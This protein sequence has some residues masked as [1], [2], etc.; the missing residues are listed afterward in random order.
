L[1]AL[2]AAWGLALVASA[3][4]GSGGQVIEGR[5]LDVSSA[6][7]WR[8]C[9]DLDSNFRCSP[10]EPAT[11]TKVA[12][13]RLQGVQSQ[14]VAEGIDSGQDDRPVNVYVGGASSDYL[15]SPL[16]TLVYIDAAR[17]GRS[18]V[19]SE[20]EIRDRV[21]LPASEPGLT[22]DYLETDAA[23]S[24]LLGQLMTSYQRRRFA[25]AQSPVNRLL[26]EDVV[27]GFLSSAVDLSDDIAVKNAVL[28]GSEGGNASAS[29]G[30]LPALT[31]LPIIQGMKLGAGYDVLGDRVRSAA[32]CIQ[33]NG[34]DGGI[35]KE[36]VIS[37]NDIHYEYRLIRSRKDLVEFLNLNS[38]I[39][40]NGGDFSM[41]VFFDFL[42]NYEANQNKLYA[43]VKVD[44]RVADIH[45][46][47]PVMPDNVQEMFMT[48]Y[49]LFRK[50]C[51][52]QFLNVITVGGVYYGIIEIE[53]HS[54]QAKLQ[55]EAKLDIKISDMVNIE[56]GFEQVLKNAF[57]NER[58]SV[59]IHS[60]GAPAGYEPVTNYSGFIED[61]TRFYCNLRGVPASMCENIC[62]RKLQQAGESASSLSQALAAVD[63]TLDEVSDPNDID[64]W[65]VITGPIEHAVYAKFEDYGQVVDALRSLTVYEENYNKGL[66]GEHY[67]A[68][69]QLYEETQRMLA[70]PTLWED[71]EEQED[72]VVAK[73]AELRLYLDRIKSL[74][75]QCAHPTERHCVAL[76]NKAAL[77]E[78]IHQGEPLSEEELRDEAVTATEIRGQLPARAEVLPR[79]C[80]DIKNNPHLHNAEDVYL[81]YLDGDRNQPYWVYCYGMQLQ[82]PPQEYLILR[83]RSVVQSDAFGDLMELPNYNYS[84]FKGLPLP[85]PSSDD[86]SQPAELDSSDTLGGAGTTNAGSI[87]ESEYSE[88]PRG[89]IVS[90]YQMIKI[91]VNRDNVAIDPNQHVSYDEHRAEPDDLPSTA[92]A[93][94]PAAGSGAPSD[95]SMVS[96]GDALVEFRSGRDSTFELVGRYRHAPLGWTKVCDRNLEAGTVLDGVGGILQTANINIQGTPFQLPSDFEMGTNMRFKTLYTRVRFPEARDTARLQRGALLTLRGPEDIDEF[97]DI[98]HQLGLAGSWLN[99]AFVGEPDGTVAL[100]WPGADD[101]HY[102]PFGETGMPAAE[103]LDGQAAYL[104]V[105]AGDGGEVRGDVLLRDAATPLPFLIEY[106]RGDAHF[107]VGPQRQVLDVFASH[108]GG[109][110]LTV[111]PVR[112]ILLNYNGD[113]ARTIGLID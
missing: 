94:D 29:F 65:G 104:Q 108:L 42:S 9:D 43:A 92:E 36:K 88:L 30:A 52:D 38:S 80:L 25:V 110:C 98:L 62:R 95:E 22:E 53:T 70:F 109:D 57:N 11:V 15:L 102:N 90:A 27:E 51:G 49:E 48:D 71:M 64:E 91:I 6:D 5:L 81:L 76:T 19:D 34:H 55:V 28:A 85:P 79:T 84:V 99:M 24:P 31:D 20:A 93:S 41:S 18:L 101:V 61:V 8:V 106:I 77:W 74:V 113:I 16:S 40:V 10:W 2:V 83:N 44:A 50:K 13:F 26:Q 112:E 47:N 39:G 1:R 78:H 58:V 86:S 66:M 56:T 54:A 105:I 21:G 17:R 87:G 32:Q 68:Y 4:G 75:T 35:V 73:R 45:I 60:A 63:G 14:L 97:A 23:L 3:C 72:E 69:Y 46:K 89:N 111:Y 12:N 100:T 96:F 33:T 107:V 37:R 7:L 103:E 67:D 59:T 82:A